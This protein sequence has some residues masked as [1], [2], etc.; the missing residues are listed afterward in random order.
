MRRQCLISTILVA[1][2]LYPGNSQTTQSCDSTIDGNEAARLLRYAEQK[3]K[4]SNVG[5]KIANV[6][7]VTGTCY[8]RVLVRPADPTNN[9][10]LSLFLSPDHRFIST[11]LMDLDVDPSIA[12]RAERD[13]IDGL[14]NQSKSPAVGRIEAPVKVVFFS[15]FQCPYCRELDK[16]VRERVMKEET[17]K[18]VLIVKQMPLRSHTLARPAAEAAM[19][20]YDQGLY[21]DVHN[22]LFDHQN[23]LGDFVST[24]K[25]SALGA[26]IPKLDLLRFDA[27][28]QSGSGAQKV[29]ADSEIAAAVGTRVTP[30]VFI[31]GERIEGLVDS[32]DLRYRIEEAARLAEK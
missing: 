22:F 8:Q 18:M 31:N 29:Q 30:T 10:A 28:L 15:D 27:C 2:L 19:C 6:E 13:R 26:A 4:F 17:G 16:V 11:D 20:A 5:L 9:W 7:D 14:L 24:E 21:W 23:A 25:S 3:A 12:A 32:V 1:S